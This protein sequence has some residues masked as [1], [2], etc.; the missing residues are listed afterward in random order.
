MPINRA[1]IPDFKIHYKATVTKTAWD[2]DNNRYIDRWNTIGGP[3]INLWSIT[4][5]E[6][7]QED[8]MGKGQCLQ[9]MVG[10]LDPY[11]TPYLKTNPKQVKI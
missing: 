3:E 9:L 2:W 1:T 10:K 6:E 11:L 5:L 7:S 8:T 4:L